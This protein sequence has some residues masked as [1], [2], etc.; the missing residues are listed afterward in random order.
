M[1]VNDYLMK[2][3]CYKWFILQFMEQSRSTYFSVERLAELLGLSRYL[4]ERY[5]I[6]V[7]QDLHTSG[8]PPG[9]EVAAD[10]EII[11]GGI[12]HELVKIMR[13]FY[14]QESLTY[15]ELH[16]FLTQEKSID[17]LLGQLPS[18]R[19]SLYRA[20]KAVRK[21][22]L[23]DEI[24]LRKNRLEGDEFRLR[25]GLYG[26]YYDIYNGLDSPFGEEIKK[27]RQRLL[28]RM[29]QYR[30][31]SLSPSK[32]HQLILFL[33]IW[34]TRLHFGHTL[35]VVYVNVQADS[36]V[37]FLHRLLLEEFQ[38][39]VDQL[40][41]EICY[42]YQFIDLLELDPQLQLDYLPGET[43]T[44]ATTLAEELV[45]GLA[46]E[47]GEEGQQLV[48]QLHQQLMQ[49]LTRINRRWLY[50]HTEEAT[51][52]TKG[53]N[54]YFQEINPV[55]NRV[56]MDQIKA[57]HR[58]GLF[59]NEREQNKLYYD[60]LFFLVATIPVEQLESPIYICVDFSHGEAYNSYIRLM[61]SSL[62]SMHL[63]YEKKI[64]AQTQIYLSDSICRKLNC[65]QVIWKRPPTPVDWGAF[66]DLLLEVK[67]RGE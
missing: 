23:Q 42:L 34:L 1:R 12:D 60:Y 33:D 2:D 25:S 14:L 37:G 57:N 16:F 66:G 52:I 11:I 39:T 3:E 30:Q 28:A 29:L 40:S 38:L 19:S 24:H 46:Q 15:Q 8:F 63:C 27:I 56:V 51:F 67:K 4:V 54:R 9:F 7:A 58:R 26:F 10:G 48:T 17:D 45:A 21:L 47:M 20:Q 43:D 5:L 32:E 41:K 55:L 18:S 61:L 53:E 49:G 13:L 65:R 62:K 44:L 22:L 59:Y 31:M 50:Y 35:D 6:E 36:F 64:S